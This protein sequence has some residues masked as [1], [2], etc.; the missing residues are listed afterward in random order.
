MIRRPPRSTLFPYTTLFRSARGRHEAWLARLVEE[1]RSGTATV[2][3][4]SVVDVVARHRDADG[5]RLD[6][7]TA[8][9][10]VLNVIRPTVAISWFLA[11]SGHA[12]ARWPQYRELL[13]SGEQAFTEAW[14]HEVRRFY[15]FAPL[16]GGPAPEGGQGGRGGES[17]G[18]GG[19][20]GLY[21]GE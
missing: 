1:V 4:G 21:R 7:R 8:A 12:L 3:A 5:E 2:P 9:V 20:V 16:I 19:A 18:G 17:G 13:A 11:F 15:P 14:A 10:E 6:P